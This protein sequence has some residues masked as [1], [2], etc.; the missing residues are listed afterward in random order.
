[1]RVSL[2]LLAALAMLPAARAQAHPGCPVRPATLAAMRGCYRPLLVFSPSATDP[3]LARQQ[4]SLDQAADDMMDRDVLL[5][6]VLGDAAHYQQPLDAPSAVLPAAELAAARQR[7]HVAR[8]QF[9][10]ILLGE[11]GGSKLSRS[12]PVT[13][14]RLNRLI[15]TMPT[16]RREMQQPHSN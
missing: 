14:D 4:A 5:L 6:P 1:M 10:V 15:D 16:R 3:R 11:A 7:F 13:V 8:D 9:R 12:T 2:A